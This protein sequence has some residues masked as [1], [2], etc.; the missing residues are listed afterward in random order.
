[1]RLEFS[2]RYGV[3]GVYKD[4]DRAIWRF[5][6]PFVRVSVSRSRRLDRNN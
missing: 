1:M 3:V 5:Y 6:I 2:L 4:R